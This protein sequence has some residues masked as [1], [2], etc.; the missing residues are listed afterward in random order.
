MF[1]TALWGS[2]QFAVDNATKNGDRLEL[3]YA[4]GGWQEGQGPSDT[5]SSGAAFLE[6]VF[7][8][9]DAAGEWYFD[10]AE[11]QLYLLP[12]S[13]LPALQAAELAVPVLDSIVVISGSQASASSYASSISFSG[14]TFTETRST[15]LEQY[16]APSSG[17]WTVFR[18]G[19]LFI[20]DAENVTVAGCTF[21]QTG[22]TALALSN[23]VL[24]SLVA[25]CEF[26]RTGESGVIMLGSTQGQNASLPTYP[27]RNTV[28]RCHCHETGVYGKQ[29]SCVA[30]LLAANTSIL[31]TVA[32][33]SPRAALNDVDGFGGGKHYSGNVVFNNVRETGDHGPLNTWMRMPYL[34][35][36][37]NAD[38][39][40]RSDG[41]SIVKAWDEVKA[42]LVIN[43]YSGVWAS[44]RDDASQFVR[45]NGNFFLWG[46]CKNFRGCWKECD[47]N[48]ILSVQ[49]SSRHPLDVRD[50]SPL[51]PPPSIPLSLRDPLCRRYP[52]TASRSHGAQPCQGS[53]VGNGNSE[54]VGNVCATANGVSYAWAGCD[55]RPNSVN[56]SV[57]YTALNTHLVDAGADFNVSCGDPQVQLG[58][59]QWQ[60]L[61]Q[62]GGSSTSATPDVAALIALGAAKVLGGRG[63][64]GGAAASTLS[65]V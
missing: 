48:V 63:G 56:G 43:G 47:D 8:E 42:N 65:L 45:D 4:Y 29:T 15:F 6:N 27:D 53:Y 26:V 12:N 25:D 49:D 38:G 33:N 41:L 13:S 58:F 16:E 9:L 24:G 17:D 14:F 30:S 22:G 20:Q 39:F 60:A 57:Y 35:F 44:D 40:N 50:G 21:D 34:S 55:T 3:R 46:G 18:S 11:Q 64:S 37:G 2:W 54:H 28:A 59:A 10:P 23:H 61:A 19:S 7:E 32:Y 31:D 5:R 51:S 36:S 52:G 62:D 1:H